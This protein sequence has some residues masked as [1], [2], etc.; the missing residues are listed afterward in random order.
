MVYLETLPVPPIRRENSNNDDLS[1]MY[2]S[3]INQEYIL[4]A[5]QAA[6]LAVLKLQYLTRPVLD[7]R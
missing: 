2:P 6:V 5:P 4:V 3:Q 1:T 7:A